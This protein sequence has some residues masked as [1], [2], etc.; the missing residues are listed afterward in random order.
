MEAILNLD[1]AYHI[2][3]FANRKYCGQTLREE[4]A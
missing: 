2:Y 4:M 3:E 1:W